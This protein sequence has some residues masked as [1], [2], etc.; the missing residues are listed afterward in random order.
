[1]YCFG[2]TIHGLP[3]VDA[4]FTI[5][6]KNQDL[7]Q[8]LTVGIGA[9]YFARAVIPAK[10]YFDFYYKFYNQLDENLQDTKIYCFGIENQFSRHLK[11]LL[12]G[13]YEENCFNSEA[14]AAYFSGGFEFTQN[15]LVIQTSMNY[16]QKQYPKQMNDIT[17]HD[18]S[19][20]FIIGLGYNL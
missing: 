10:V 3:Q 4:G 11:I 15:N 9:S 13:G 16:Q 8:P 14:D 20:N 5:Q 19:M 2:T 17:I 1:L 6:S 12:G 18:N 7:Q